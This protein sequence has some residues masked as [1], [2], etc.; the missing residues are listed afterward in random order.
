LNILIASSIYPETLE[1]LREQHDVDCAFNAATDVL[2]KRISDREVL[3]F[4]SGVNITADVMACAPNLKLLIRAGSGVDNIDMEY[5]ERH[6][7]Q[8]VRIPEPG[9]KAVAEMT[10][11]FMLALAR[12][13]LKADQLTRQGKWA[14][15]ELS[16]G[17]LLTGKTLGVVGAGNIGARVGQMGAAW[18]MRVLGC[19]ERPSA[20]TIARLQESGI[21]L[22]SFEEIISTAD[23]VSLHVPLK[24]TTRNLFDAAT[25]AQMKPG[26]YLINLARGGV[27]DEAALYQA[28]VA[29]HLSGAALDVHRQEGNGHISPLASLSN[30]ILTPHIGAGAIDS[31]REIGERIEEILD[32]FV[33]HEMGVRFQSAP[34]SV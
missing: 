33:P 12:N 31:Q 29:G 2:Q 3:I 27:V 20:Q 4:R 15:R 18:G 11:A 24:E 13:L 21:R 26:A 9:A 30:V 16:N 23:F 22:A 8:L 1:R 17:H 14:K 28:L 6:G 32:S 7:L 5:V 25:L 10:F 19:V 34:V